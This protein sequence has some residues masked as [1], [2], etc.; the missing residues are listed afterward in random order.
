MSSIGEWPGFPTAAWR[1]R[2]TYIPDDVPWEDRHRQTVVAGRS[3]TIWA[4]RTCDDGGTTK[5]TLSPNDRV[6]SKAKGRAAR[7]GITLTRF[8]RGC[9]AGAPC[10]RAHTQ[11]SLPVA[12]GDG[13]GKQAAQHGFCD[14]AGARLP[15]LAAVQN[16]MRAPCIRSMRTGATG[17]R[18]PGGSAARTVTYL[19]RGWRATRAAAWRDSPNGRCRN[20]TTR[21][22][23]RSSPRDGHR[24]CPLR[25]SPSL[26]SGS[27]GTG[28]R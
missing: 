25:R 19:V 9:P 4:S 15:A 11:G 16:A 3:P 21:R 20:A 1:G 22:S 18:T 7:E 8:R 6:L 2:D 13:D 12:A 23:R 27:S 28:S 10:G 5:A 14:R 26:R 17:S 24:R